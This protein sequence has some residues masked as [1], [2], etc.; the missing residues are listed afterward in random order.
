MGTAPLTL[1]AILT[2]LAVA[3]CQPG[4]AVTPTASPAP[5]PPP[6]QPRPHQPAPWPDRPALPRQPQQRPM[7]EPSSPCCRSA[8]RTPGRTTAAPTGATGQATATAAT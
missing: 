6:S 3:G 4:H 1:T 5:R 2:A 7:R 8:P